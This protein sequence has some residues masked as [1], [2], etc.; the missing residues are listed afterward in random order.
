MKPPRP[1]PVP[2]A[3]LFPSPEDVEARAKAWGQ[4]TDA[5]P[6]PATLRRVAPPWRVLAVFVLAAAAIFAGPK[7]GTAAVILL[8]WLA[9]SE[10]VALLRDLHTSSRA[11][12]ETAP[13]LK[14]TK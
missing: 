12:H 10:L 4:L 8:G 3:P 6:A 7:L 1:K 11:V 13:T 5:N 9:A 14:E 2:A